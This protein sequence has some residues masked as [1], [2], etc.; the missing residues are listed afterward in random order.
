MIIFVRS[1]ISN[2][3]IKDS[4]AMESLFYLSITGQAG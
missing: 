2:F 1:T 3:I 4:S